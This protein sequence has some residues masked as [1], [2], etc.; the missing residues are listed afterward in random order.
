MFSI[1][2]V[3]LVGGSYNAGRVEVYYSGVWG[4]VCDDFWDIDD[5]RVVCRQLGFQDALNAYQNAHYGQGTGPILLDDVSCLGNE[6]SLLSCRH[7][8]VR[9]HNCGHSEDASVV[10]GENGGE[11]NL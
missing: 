7:G 2:D 6:S 8:G 10:C 4:T 9:N 3:Q 1:L 11:N 5:A